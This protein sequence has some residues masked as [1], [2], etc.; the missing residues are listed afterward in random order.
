VGNPYIRSNDDSGNRQLQADDISNA[1]GA[2]LASIGEYGIEGRTQDT[3]DRVSRFWMEWLD[4]PD[5]RLTTFPDEG[6]DEMVVVRGIG[7]YSMCEHHCLPFFGSVDVG[8][9]PDGRIIGLSK[10]PRMVDHFSRRLQN[11]ERLTK[12]ITDALSDL[13]TPRGVAVVTRARHMC[14]EMRGIKTSAHTVTSSLTGVFRDAPEV[15]G[16]FMRLCLSSNASTDA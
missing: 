9:I 11:Q 14:M 8:Y 15:R 1:H 7:F 10:I 3:P 12:Q 5:V 13:L 4:A 2:F 16:E 6:C